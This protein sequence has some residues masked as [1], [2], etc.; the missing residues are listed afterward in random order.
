MVRV[1]DADTYDLL[2]GGRVERVRLVGVDAPELSQP[3]GPQAADSV[4]RLLP[5]G[6]LVQLTRASGK[7]DLYGR[8]LGALRLAAGI[9]PQLPRPVAVDSLL[10]VRGWAWA[11][12]PGRTTPHLAAEQVVAQAHGRGLWKCG[13]LEPVPPHVWRGFTSRIKR[14][15]W[16][17]CPW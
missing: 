5:V 11:W 13:V 2:V 9:T 15:Y 3:Y 14:L 7:P 4:R 16:G 10:V 6:Q 17:G 12:E 8:T 1:I